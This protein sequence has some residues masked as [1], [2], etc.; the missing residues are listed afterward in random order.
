MISAGQLRDVIVFLVGDGARGESGSQNSVW[1]ELFRTR[2]SV[3]FLKGSRAL[4]ADSAWNPTTIVVTTRQDSRLGLFLRL[5]VHDKDYYIESMNED[6]S[7]RS[8]TITASQINE[9]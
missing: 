6:E 3:K 7:D 9:S 1:R 5:R 2:G 8:V 4:M